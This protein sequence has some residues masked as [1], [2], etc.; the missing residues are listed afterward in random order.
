MSL[1]NCSRMHVAD[2]NIIF[3]ILVSVDILHSL[4]LYRPVRLLKS[5][6]LD[7]VCQIDFACSVCLSKS[8]GCC[9]V[10][11]PVTS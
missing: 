7:Q 8:N 11:T 5:Q 4:K 6:M 9:T 3:W 10:C 2:F 1:I